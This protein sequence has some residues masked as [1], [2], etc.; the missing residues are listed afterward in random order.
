MKFKGAFI[1]FPVVLTII[2]ADCVG[3]GGGTQVTDCGTNMACFYAAASVCTPAKIT[4]P[5][6][7]LSLYLETRQATSQCQLYAKVLSGPASA[8]GFINKEMLCPMPSD[9]ANLSFSEEY[10]GTCVGT[11]ADELKT[12]LNPSTAQACSDGTAYSQCSSTKPQY[13][14]NGLLTDKCSSCGCPSGTTCDQTFQACRAQRCSDGTRYNECSLGHSPIYCDNGAIVNKCSVCDC[15][16]GQSC[17]QTNNQCYASVNSQTCSDGTI[18]GQ[19]STTKPKYCSNNNLTNSCL[20]CGCPTGQSCNQTSNSCYTP[21]TTLTCSDGTAYGQC[22]S[23]KPLYCENGQ[24]INKCSVCDCTYYYLCNSTSNNCF[25]Y[26]VPGQQVDCGR[27]LTIFEIFLNVSMR[28][29]AANCYLQTFVTCSPSK[30]IIP[31]PSYDMEVVVKGAEGNLCAVNETAVWVNE[32]FPKLVVGDSMICIN[33]VGDL[34]GGIGNCT[35]S[36]RDH[37][38]ENATC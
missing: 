32:S 16:T 10:L 24:L 15:P 37:L 5:Y 25:T 13:C 29:D 1:L 31:S 35:G 7:D 21:A 11:L 6:N 8:S 28:T 14:D 30:T 34:N 12:Y 26:A 27:M 22:S 20:N 19:C 2:L 33:T 9:L 17:N 23:T 18:Y 36:L 3:G 4:T 38:C